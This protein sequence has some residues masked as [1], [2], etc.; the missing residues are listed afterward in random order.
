M[1]P[2][3]EDLWFAWLA[4]DT[5]LP[6]GGDGVLLTP[7]LPPHLTQGLVDRRQQSMSVDRRSTASAVS[8]QSEE[9]GMS[10]ENTHLQVLAIFYIKQEACSLCKVRKVQNVGEIDADF[11]TALKSQPQGGGVSH[12]RNP[13]KARTFMA[14]PTFSRA[15]EQRTSHRVTAVYFKSLVPLPKLGRLDLHGKNELEREKE[16]RQ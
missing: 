16:G 11:R 3:T 13:L 14:T 4:S 12:P 8:F 5:Q 7:H 6:V 15:K 9:D 1:H 10:R 2:T